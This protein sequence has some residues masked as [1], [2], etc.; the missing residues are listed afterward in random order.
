MSRYLSSDDKLAIDE[1]I[2]VIEIVIV[3]VVVDPN[4]D[5]VQHQNLIT[6]RRS[7]L[8]HAYHVWS[9]SVNAFV[10]YPAHTTERM[11]ETNRRNDHI[12]PP[13]FAE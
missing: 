1:I 7:P 6:S 13:A 3:V 10:S 2:I 11:T 8:S 5:L 9:T 4:P 12:T